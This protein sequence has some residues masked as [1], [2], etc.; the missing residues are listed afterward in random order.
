[1]ERVH[2]ALRD[3]SNEATRVDA[4]GLI[5]PKAAPER[6]ILWVFFSYA[7]LNKAEQ[8]IQNAFFDLLNEKLAYP[9]ADSAH[10]PKIKLWRD[11]HHISPTRPGDSQ[12]DEGC[13]KAFLGILMVSNKFP[14]SPHC[15]REA[16]YF[17][18]D[19]G[20]DQNGKICLVIN[21]NLPFWA[22]PSRSEEHTS[23][24]Q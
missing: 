1:M 16:S 7:T 12:M 4:G 8:R 5:E 15:R 6:T 23:E 10:L 14:H 17:L 3:I 24:L 22:S 11:E 9:P 19:D 20:E 21:V 18:T 13:A 2:D